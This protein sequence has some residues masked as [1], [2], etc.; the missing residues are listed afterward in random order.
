[1]TPRRAALIPVYVALIFFAVITLIP[2]IWMITSALKTPEDYFTS[3][4]LPRGEGWGG[5]AWERLTADNFRRL[6]REFPI[7]RAM[8][9]SCMLASVTSTLATFICAMGG[10]GLAKFSFRGRT[11]L[12]SLVLGALIIPG[13]LLIAPSYQLLWQLGLLNSYAGLILPAIAP[14]F[15]VFLF[16]QAMLNAVPPELLEAARIDGAGEFRIFFTIVIPL[17]RPMIGAFLLITFLGAWNNFIGPQIALQSPEAFPLSVAI[18]NLR[19]LHGTEYGLIMSGTLVS[20]AP[21]MC[22]FLLLQ[23]DFISGLTSGAVKG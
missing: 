4:F 21:V 2:F 11:W 5:I 16:R 17:V 6:F 13:P 12:T 20:I 9:N 14:A 3:F 15:G 7:G 8:V 18:N 10:Y 22:L 19:G 23:R 1:M